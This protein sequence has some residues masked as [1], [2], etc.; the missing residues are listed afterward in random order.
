MLPYC[1][2]TSV[3]AYTFVIITC[4]SIEKI[5]HTYLPWYNTCE[6]KENDA[7]NNNDPNMFYKQPVKMGVQKD[8]ECFLGVRLFINV[9]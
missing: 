3:K 9:A 7:T 2:H 6:N 5:L 4:T 1:G 8:S